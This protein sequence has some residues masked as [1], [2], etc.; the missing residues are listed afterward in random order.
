VPSRAPRCM[1]AK[2]SLNIKDVPRGES[3]LTIPEKMNV[4][5]KISLHIVLRNLI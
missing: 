1:A 2:Y 4:R 5:P 3:S